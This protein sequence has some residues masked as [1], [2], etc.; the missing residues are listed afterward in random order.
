V[1][2]KY[3]SHSFRRIIIESGGQESHVIQKRNI[4]NLMDWS[5]KFYCF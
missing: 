3:H 4:D 5:I 2:M 1:I